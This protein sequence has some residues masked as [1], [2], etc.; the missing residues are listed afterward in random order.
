MQLTWPREDG[1]QT[2]PEQEIGIRGCREVG[3]HWKLL[4]ASLYDLE[5]YSHFDNFSINPKLFS[6]E[7]DSEATRSL[8]I[9]CREHTRLRRGVCKERHGK[10]ALS[11]KVPL[12]KVISH[13]GKS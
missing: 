13:W 3:S 9:G 1:Q 6:H 2:F 7:C 11:N 4:V 10:G 12:G 8:I 5:V